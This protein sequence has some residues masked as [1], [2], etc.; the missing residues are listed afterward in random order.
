M[1]HYAGLER[2]RPRNLRSVFSA[3]QADAPAGR[4]PVVGAGQ[5]DQLLSLAKSGLVSGEIGH[6][7]GPAHHGDVGSA[8]GGNAGLPVVCIGTRACQGFNKMRDQQAERNDQGI[9]HMMR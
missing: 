5:D 8:P 2:F 6:W 3:R 1:T 7:R 9:A 4:T